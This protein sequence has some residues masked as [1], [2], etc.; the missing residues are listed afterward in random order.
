MSTRLEDIAPAAREA[1][2]LL[3]LDAIG[4][5][6]ANREAPFAVAMRAVVAEADA[7]GPCTVIGGGGRRA[8]PEAAAEVNSSL[9]HGSD[10]DAT[11]IESII[12]PTSIAVPVAVAVG[13]AADARGSEVLAAMACGM[14][15]LVRLG[16]AAA[17]QFHRRGY[18]PTALL[19]SIVAAIVAARLRGR[20][21]GAA[22]EAAG[23]ATS[24][25]AGLR[26]FS[27]DGTWG[28][29]LITAWACRTGIHA[30]ALVAA[31]FR[32]SRDALEKSWGL[33][34]AF[35]PEGGF[36][37][38][39]ATNQLGQTWTLIDTE[40]KRYPCSH[41]LHPYIEAARALS[42]RVSADA[43][44]TVGLRVNEAAVRWWFEPRDL[45]YRPDVY[46]AR[47]SLPYVVAR[48]ILDGRVDEASFEAEAVEDSAVLALADRV[49]PI[50]DPALADRAPVGLP[51]GLTI[52]LRDGTAIE[53]ATAPAPSDTEAFVIGRFRVA[54]TGALGAGRAASL[55]RSILGIAGAP[56]ARSV[57][58]DAAT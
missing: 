16:L 52:V 20:S 49:V 21:T 34:P 56:S 53:I 58:A 4:T 29:R 19:G 35:L 24:V 39:L 31:G 48:A 3:L 14:E 10:L 27:S 46:A 45:R 6:L 9:V 41:G 7:G 15:V 12:H 11:H 54:A 57:L 40:L 17:G 42:D 26:S 33:F 44:V 55:E 43:V 32:G 1:A 50:V 30:E 2:T 51:G 13:E 36:D 28:K 25:S 47:F 23:L 5:A 37:L 18:Q 8:G 38:S 22:V